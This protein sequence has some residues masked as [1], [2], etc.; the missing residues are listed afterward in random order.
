M[1]SS[2]CSIVDLYESSFCR[3]SCVSDAIRS[4]DLNIQLI[5]RNKTAKSLPE[6][7]PD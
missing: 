4:N 1:V 3:Q 2:R 5:H 7:S 6:F